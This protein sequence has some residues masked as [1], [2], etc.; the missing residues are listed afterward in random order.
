LQQKNPKKQAQYD[1]K[2]DE[3]SEKMVDNETP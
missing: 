3:F 1:E 2:N